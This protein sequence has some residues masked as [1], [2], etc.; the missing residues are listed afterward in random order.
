MRDNLYIGERGIVDFT[1]R[2]AYFVLLCNTLACVKSETE[3]GA[4]ASTSTFDVDV[5]PRC[6]RD[7]EPL[8]TSLFRDATENRFATLPPRANY[9]SVVDLNSDH[10][11]DL[12][13]RVYPPVANDP[14]VGGAQ[15]S[16]VYLNEGGT[17]VDKTLEVNLDARSDGSRALFLGASFGDI[18][19]DG[20]IDAV[21]TGNPEERGEAYGLGE[22]IYNDGSFDWSDNPREILTWLGGDAHPTGVIMMNVDGDSELEILVSQGGVTGGPL[23]TLLFD[24]LD[25]GS[26]RELSSGYAMITNPW[27]NVEQVNAAQGHARAWGIGRC[28]LNSDM[29]PEVLVSSYGRAPNHLWRQNRETSFFENIALASGFA[30]DGDQDWTTNHFAQCF[31]SENPSADACEGVSIS[32]PFG[33][34]DTRWDHNTGREAFRLGGNSGSTLCGDLD[35]DGDNDLVTLEIQHWWAGGNSDPSTVLLN[36]ST[37]DA[38]SLNRMLRSESGFDFQHVGELSGANGNADLYGWHEGHITGALADINLDGRLDILV[39][40]TD[41]HENRLNLF[42]QDSNGRFEES[43]ILH[44]IDNPRTHGVAAAD[45][46]RDGDI[47]IVL[48]HSRNRCSG[49]GEYDCYSAADSHLRFFE[50]QVNETSASITILAVGPSESAAPHFA[51][52]YVSAEGMAE[53]VRD[54]ELSYGHYGQQ[55]D[56]ALTFGLRENCEA[57]VRVQFEDG[58][59]FQY[60]LAAGHYYVVSKDGAISKHGFNDGE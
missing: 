53:Q 46:D 16:W 2:C 45:F 51:R 14:S 35:N 54:I 48:G 36:E 30:F 57:D 31:C 43:A 60:S 5:S 15:S 39:G 8:E 56:H 22:V 33:C 41:Y 20:L 29:F 55:N 37:S 26:W 44:G 9:L 25:D 32:A 59:E 1:V 3:S 28:D 27:F 47:D 12:V 6:P 58:S 18:N 52:V 4:N 17:L 19:K 7:S 38:I 23:P 42:L 40:A 34:G 49:A 24:H 21:L 10:W 50:N 13:A 11:P